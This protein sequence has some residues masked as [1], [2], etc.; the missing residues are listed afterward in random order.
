M[1]SEPPMPAAPPGALASP[2]GSAGVDSP[3]RVVAGY[4]A[5]AVVY[6]LLAIYA[7][8]LPFNSVPPYDVWPAHGIAL[9]ALLASSPR[10]WPILMALVLVSSAAVSLGHGQGWAMAASTSALD[11]LEPLLVAVGLGR[12]AGSVADFEKARA[13]APQLF[14][15]VE[16]DA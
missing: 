13:L 2:T 7:A 16:A 11:V 15:E 12:L 5:F 10:R 14:A 6:G 1:S 9:G 4:A 8:A 3:S